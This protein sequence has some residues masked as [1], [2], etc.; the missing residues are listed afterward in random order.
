MNPTDRFSNRADTYR[1]YR[2]S[3][4]AALIDLIRDTVPLHAGA[5]VAD[6]GSGTGIL[7]RL[8]LEAGFDV[9]AVEPNEAMR[10]AAEEYLAVFPHFHSVA[11][12]AEQTGLP[13]ASFEAI[14]VAQAFHWFDP[15]K[16]RHEF[17]RL[18]RPGGWVFLIRNQWQADTSPFLADYEKLLQT[19]GLPHE[20]L[21]HRNQ[22][23]ADAGRQIFFSGCQ[24]RSATF[25]NPHRL[26]WAG[27]QGRFLSASYAPPPGDPRH[28]DYLQRLEQLFHRHARNGQVTLAQ[29][30]E[31]H[32][33]R[34]VP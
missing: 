33:G 6:I 2:P 24:P 10:L 17:Q 1:R 14:T 5:P 26:D 12:P 16:A 7:T 28:E 20:E 30:T 19:L 13:D 34:L 3:Y 8:L 15:S 11:A 18:L 29:T 31:V 32:Y 25:D 27:L 9:T 22:H 21:A 23:A 4:P